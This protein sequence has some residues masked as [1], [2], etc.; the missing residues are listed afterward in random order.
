MQTNEQRFE[1]YYRKQLML[2]N[3]DFQEMLE[4]FKEPLMITFKILRA[5]NPIPKN[6]SVINVTD[7]M[8]HQEMR[9]RPIKLKKIEFF[10]DSDLVY[11]SNEFALNGNNDDY[12]NNEFFEFLKR[13]QEL[14]TISRQELVSM[15]PVYCL[16]IEEFHRVLD[17]CAA[18]GSKTTQILEI[19][20]G[21]SFD[22]SVAGV[23]VAN[24]ASLTRANQLTSRCQKMKSHCLIVTNHEA[25]VY[26]LE[27]ENT[28]DRILCDVPCSGDGTLRKSVDLWKKWTASSG[29]ILH[30]LQ[31]EIVQRA[32]RLLKVGGKLVY[33]TC[34]L[35]P[36][37]NEAVVYE[38]LKRASGSIRLVDLTNVLPKMKRREG[39][40]T[41]EVQDPQTF[42]WYKKFS[43]MK[44]NNSNNSKIKPSMFP[45][46]AE[47]DEEED[48]NFSRSSEELKKCMRLYPHL[49]DTGGFFVACF[50]K[51]SE[52]PQSMIA[53]DEQNKNKERT[54]TA[55][56]K[57]WLKSEIAP[58]ITISK[59]SEIYKSIKNFYGFDLRKSS[60]SKLELI[61][62]RNHSTT[63]DYKMTT[64]PKRIYVLSSQAHKIIQKCAS[65]GELFVLA[66]GLSIFAR[67]AGGYR[68]TQAG[69]DFFASKIEKQV[70]R[71][72]PKMLE[73]ILAKQQHENDDE[74]ID[75]TNNK[76][77]NNVRVDLDEK[78][79]EDLKKHSNGCI[80]LAIRGRSSGS[81][82]KRKLEEE[83]IGAVSVVTAC[84][85]YPPN[86]TGNNPSLSLLL[87]K[88]EG[89]LKLRCLRESVKLKLIN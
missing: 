77:T 19:L 25:Q 51:V 49:N 74:I 10:N 55:L 84:C 68:F 80:I 43:T 9:D 21:S 23:C 56:K 42:S 35:N 75:N 11:Q 44:N 3:K 64:T 30:S 65:S 50:Q 62:R 20:N 73:S 54:K 38:L 36:I 88:S 29:L 28:F 16:D 5:R 82:N 76:N 18:P 15:I 86:K 66:C 46:N 34:S 61:T 22:A 59:E 71:V 13:E 79:K 70:I 89:E 58:V 48:E 17:T 12:K 81:G 7:K 4:R 2:T 53:L 67:Q 72:S 40:T 60:K 69:A 14:G 78:T 83:E 63:D 87:T 31:L 6:D 57:K 24:D 26:P 41:W 8:L 39:L 37:E 27:L 45:P 85:W 52:L 33:S 32:F 1:N 47:D